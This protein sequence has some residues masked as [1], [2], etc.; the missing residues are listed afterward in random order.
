[1]LPMEALPTRPWAAGRPGVKPFSS[2]GPPWGH[3][4]LDNSQP[5]WVP[6]AQA[7]RLT[8]RT[9]TQVSPSALATCSAFC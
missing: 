9:L 4:S 1:M 8:A 6:G 5:T 3:P 7:A 2:Q